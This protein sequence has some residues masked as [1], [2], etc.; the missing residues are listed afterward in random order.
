METFNYHN[1]YKLFEQHL[2]ITIYYI[3]LKYNLNF[4]FYNNNMTNVRFFFIIN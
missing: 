3:N 4:H 1:S 2:S